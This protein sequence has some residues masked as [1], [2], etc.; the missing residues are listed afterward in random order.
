MYCKACDCNYEGWTRRCPV[1]KQT[2]Q[3]SDSQEKTEDFRTTNYADLVELVRKN[4]GSL[5]IPLFASQV[6]RKKTTRFPWLGFGYAW[7][8]KMKGKKNGISVELVT[9]EV[10]KSHSS[11]FPYRGR[12]YAW[13]EKMEGT[14]DGNKLSLRAMNVK[15]KKTWSF[16]F[17]GYGYAWTEDMAGDC[18]S[19]IRI[20]LSE[21]KIFR[22][23]RWRFPY[24]GFGYAWAKESTLTLNLN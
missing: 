2:L 12:G 9:S 3:T 23:R 17:S 6:I 16:P 11:S 20:E 7:T 14:I 18:G 24:F 15:R 21:P 1:C 10:G 19:Q 13:R 4:G 8:Q 5:N 22:Y